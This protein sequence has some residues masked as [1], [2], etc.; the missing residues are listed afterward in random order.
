MY[1]DAEIL[2]NFLSQQSKEIHD[3]FQRLK[4]KTGADFDQ[5]TNPRDN[6]DEPHS[7]Y[8][9]LREIMKLEYTV[10]SEHKSLMECFSNDEKTLLNTFNLLNADNDGI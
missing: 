6:P 2:G 10:I 9:A 7:N 8:F 4:Q 1:G 3:V 5:T